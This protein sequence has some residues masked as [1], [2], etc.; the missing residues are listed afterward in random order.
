LDI[1]KDRLLFQ[2]NMTSD[3]ISSLI[4]TYILAIRQFG[5]DDIYESLKWHYSDVCSH[6][7]VVIRNII[8]MLHEQS[9]NTSEKMY[10]S[11]STIKDV[12]KFAYYPEETMKEWME[13]GECNPD[14]WWAS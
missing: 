13:E 6:G 14:P 12:E 5:E 8:N 3:N 7:D 11:L 10:Q 1:L 2:A 9:H 4:S